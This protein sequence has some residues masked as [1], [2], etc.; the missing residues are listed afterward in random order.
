LTQ[1]GNWQQIIV[2]GGACGV[3]VVPGELFGRPS[4]GAKRSRFKPRSGDSW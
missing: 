1:I 4:Q 3:A 2:A